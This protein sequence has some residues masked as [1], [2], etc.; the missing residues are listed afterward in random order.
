MARSN[1]GGDAQ[2]PEGPR[3]ST[4]LGQ[5][6]PDGLPTTLEEIVTNEQLL[7][8]ATEIP[9]VV[10]GAINRVIDERDTQVQTIDAQLQNIDE[11]QA[12]YDESLS[13]IRNLRNA[14]DRLEEENEEHRHSRQSTPATTQTAGGSSTKRSAA[15]PNPPTFT[16]GK[17]LP[18][19][20]WELAI[21]NKLT[22]NGD[23]Y[24]SAAAKMGLIYS[25]VAGEA[26]K[27][28]AARRYPSAVNKFT[29]PEEVME[30]IHDNFGDP[31]EIQ[32]ATDKF[33]AFQQ[34]TMGFIDFYRE[35]SYLGGLLGYPD[36]IL[37]SNLVS[38]LNRS[39]HRE[40]RRKLQEHPHT[41]LKELKDFLQVMD[42]VNVKDNVERVQAKQERQ[43]RR[44]QS[45]RDGNKDSKAPRVTFA[46]NPTG[47]A[48]YKEKPAGSR[49]NP[50]GPR[51]CYACNSD[52]HLSNDPV[53]PKFSERRKE[54]NNAEVQHEETDPNPSSGTDS[55]ESKNE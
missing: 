33:Y 3:R 45:S 11:L 2:E 29:T 6:L 25:C 32:K 19:R 43:S 52:Q 55:D 8:C 12:Q 36:S 41:S 46:I 24:P 47:S 10:I 15:I 38:K 17:E 5:E 35:F 51:R 13:I 14:R 27:A 1:H 9:G 54:I 7:R 39:L 31:D 26:A 18:L 20:D 28:L 42:N 37:K 23:W 21:E 16:D 49:D 30:C 48:G 44:S 22:V 34:E 53:C 50:A 40:A 4:L